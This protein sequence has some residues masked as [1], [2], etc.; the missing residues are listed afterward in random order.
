[1]SGAWPGLD[2][3]A[4]RA[5]G[6]PRG[7]AEEV[8]ALAETLPEESAP[9]F[10]DRAARVFAA[11]GLP[12]EAGRFFGRARELEEARARSLG[13]PLVGE[14]A[15][16]TFVELAPSGAVGGTELC[17]HLRR[18]AQHPEPGTAHRWA[19]EAVCAVLG[20]GVVPADFVPELVRVAWAARLDEKT[21]KRFVADRLL[22]EGLMPR[23]PLPVWADLEIALRDAAADDD[24]LFDLLLAAR[25]EPGPDTAPELRA[26]YE[27]R[28]RLLVGQAAGGRP[29][30]PGWY[31]S[32]GPLRLGDMMGLAS[33]AGDRLFPRPPSPF[34]PETD[35]VARRADP[36][37]HPL[38]PAHGEQ[39][40][41]WHSNADF[42]LVARKIGED[43]RVRRDLDAF[44]RDLG[45]Y[46]NVDYPSAVRKMLKREPIRRAL[47]EQFAEWRDDCAAG[48]LD[49][50]ASSLPRL[51]PMA[52]AVAGSRRLP[53]SRDASGTALVDGVAVTDPVEAAWRALRAG[54][55]EELRPPGSWDDA[56]SVV[57]HGDL[58]TL[59]LKDGRIEVHGPGG[60][61]H[62]RELPFF[63]YERRW[64]TWPG[65]LLP[66]FDGTDLYLSRVFRGRAETYRVVGDGD[67]E[68]PDGERLPWPRSAPQVPVTFPGADGPVLVSLD[69]D[70]LRMFADG[71]RVAR[72][73]PFTGVPPGFWPH[74]APVD[75]DG[76]AALRR[77]ERD[78]VAG[79]LDAALASERVLD[80]ELA[81]VLPELTDAGLRDTVRTLLDRAAGHLRA[82]LRLC[83]ALGRERPA[84]SPARIRSVTGL[85][86][87]RHID[88]VPAVRRLAEMLGEAAGSGPAPGSPRP[89]G[90][91]EPPDVNDLLFG[92]LG[93]AALLAARPW[94]PEYQRLKARDRL[95][96][97]GDT[98]WG[99]GSGR[100]RRLPFRP[101]GEFPSGRLWR[102]P[103]GAMITLG[104]SAI[105]FAP[106]GGFRD[107]ALPGWTEESP[108]RPQGWGGAE[109]IARFLRL[110]DERGPA[111]CD[112]SAVRRLAERTGLPVHTAASAAYGFPF[113]LGRENEAASLPP[114]VAALYRDPA[115]G[116]LLR[117]ESWHLDDAL[118]EALMP[119]EPEDLWTVGLA[120]D[121]AVAWWEREGRRIAWPGAAI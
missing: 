116:E 94:T 83:D 54:L 52:E 86:A 32:I 82:A 53:M 65:A 87:G 95:G 42:L 57:L 96:A 79:L 11:R 60:V 5:A 27:R 45:R 22:R 47:A 8:L 69:G 15:H 12:G 44:V 21:E 113:T 46:D 62:E 120:V 14:E 74:L 7:A 31:R 6:D 20:S 117:H 4:A 67:L 17:G 101:T 35:P 81:R 55:P 50:L 105:E 112:V 99:D 104:R 109:R 90:E 37:P 93:G 77:L 36:R 108:P 71:R 115:T 64:L 39:A 49:G 61:A 3:V 114:E 63:G 33:D 58:L 16:R 48:D 98:P 41:S 110:L 51:V 30:P 2:E 88:Q 23:A 24:E 68:L 25:P 118:R 19:R 26:R 56:Y 66:W 89:L 80:G 10:L 76:S 119:D 9:E 1:M 107:F 102:T 73:R 100:W 91:V 106:A 75:P 84:G 13:L 78:A 40:P 72:R 28:W 38:D 18:L 103:G 92:V 70:V 59:A 85:R 29:L 43:P 97:F 111:P 34:D 121:K